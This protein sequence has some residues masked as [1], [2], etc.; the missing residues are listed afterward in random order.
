VPRRWSGSVG[1]VVAESACQRGHADDQQ[2][3]ERRRSLD[4][5]TASGI[6]V[7]IRSVPTADIAGDRHRRLR[8]G[9]EATVGML[10][11]GQA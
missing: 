7:R 2:I 9:G 11:G 10:K 6:F 4:K 3:A 8:D 1:Q 5:L